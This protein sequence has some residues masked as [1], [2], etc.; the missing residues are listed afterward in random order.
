[1]AKVKLLTLAD[2]FLAMVPKLTF[3]TTT[4][5]AGSSVTIGTVTSGTDYEVTLGLPSGPRGL[6]GLTPNFTIG[7]V[8]ASSSGG[9][10]SAALRGT[11]DNPIL[12][13]TI[14]RGLTGATPNI[15]IGSTLTSAAGGSATVSVGGTAESPV[16]TFTI[17]RG[18]TGL[19]PNLTIGT[20]STGAPG[21]SVIASFRGT[22]DNP[23]LDL[24]VPRGTTGL[25]PNLTIGNVTSSAAGTSATVSLRGTT[26]NPILDVNIPRGA[27][28][29]T[30]SITAGTITTGAPGSSVIASFRGTTDNP[31]LDLTIPRGTVGVTPAFTIGNVTTGASGTAAAAGLRGTAESPIL[32]LTIPRGLTGLTPNL[33]I[34]NVTTLTPGSNATASFRGTVDN[35][36]LDLAIPRGTA[37][38]G[39][40]DVVAANNGSEYATNKD[41]FHANLGAG[42]GVGGGRSVY[43]AT[44]AAAVRTAIGAV[45]ASAIG[46]AAM[47]NVG[48]TSGTVAVLESNG[49]FN[50]ARIPVIM[51]HALDVL[52]PDGSTTAPGLRV[53]AASSSSSVNANTAVLQLTAND[54][55]VYGSLTSPGAQQ[56]NWDG[57][58][59]LPAATN[60]LGSFFRAGTSTAVMSIAGYWNALNTVAL[61]DNASIT[62]DFSTGINFTLTMTTGVGVSRSF[63]APTNLKPGQRGFFR[64]VQPAV[65]DADYRVNW[66][67]STWKWL[68]SNTIEPRF[69]VGNSAVTTL[70]YLVTQAGEVQLFPGKLFATVSDIRVGTHNGAALTPGRWYDA[71]QP[72]GLTDAS[73]IN[74]DLS[75][76]INFTLTMT[77]GIGATRALT[78]S[79]SKVGQRGFIRFVS[80]AGIAAGTTY[81]S[82]F[83]SGFRFDG[84]T[85]PLFN[86]GPNAVTVLDYEVTAFGELTITGGKTSTLAAGSAS[87]FT[88]GTATTAVSPASYW[89]AQVPVA[90]T[91]AA[92]VAIDP[93]TG[94]NF[95]LT[96]TTAIGTSRILAASNTASKIGQRGFIRIVHPGSATPH[97]IS[98][99]SA[100]RF[101]DGV[102]IAPT[103]NQTAFGVTVIDYEITA[104]GEISLGQGRMIATS[105]DILAGTSNTFLTPATY[106][107][108]Q[109][110]TTLTDSALVVFDFATAINFNLV[111]TTAVGT[112]R[113]FTVNNPNLV[114]VGQRGFIRVVQPAGIPV[115]TVYSAAFGSN[116]RY[117]DNSTSP[118]FN[119]NANA[120]TVFDYEITASQEISITGGRTFATT[121]EFL[122]GTST[123]ALNIATFWAGQ[124]P[125]VLTDASTV[126][127][128]LSKGINFALDM[129]TATGATRTVN[130][131]NLRVGQRGFIRVTQPTDFGLNNF[132]VNW[133]SNYY[134]N[135]GADPVLNTGYTAVT[136][137]HYDV[138]SATRILLSA[139][140]PAVV[141]SEATAAEYRSATPARVLAPD[142]VWA[143]NAPVTLSE[144]D[145]QNGVN[146]NNF[147]N[148]TV[149]ISTYSY[150]YFNN[151]ANPVAAGMK[152]GQSGCITFVVP[153]AGSGGLN[154][155]IPFFS[156]NDQWF[157]SNGTVPT[158]PINNPGYTF[159]M[160]YTITSTNT[161]DVFFAMNMGRSYDAQAKAY[162]DAMT[163]QPETSRKVLINN[164]IVGLKND[165]VW[166]LLDN[167]WLLASHDNQSSRVNAVRPS[168]VLTLYGSP[169]FVT[170]LGWQATSTSGQV[171]NV[172]LQTPDA[173]NGGVNR[174][175]SA[176]DGSFGFWQ[177]TTNSETGN[178][179]LIGEATNNFY[180][181]LGH[182]S[183]N[184]LTA[185]IAGS[186]SGL[187]TG[188]QAKGLR[189]VSH[190]TGDANQTIFYN[191]TGYTSAYG[192]QN[193]M[194]G[195]AK[196][197]LLNAGNPGSYTGTTNRQAAAFTGQGMTSTQLVAMNNR[198]NTYL[199]AIGAN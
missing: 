26:D 128:D 188:G 144:A 104:S 158:F 37:G 175:Q 88:T 39:T 95:T 129:T 143:A 47:Y 19:T 20:V 141:N 180:D 90:L 167:L 171:A 108:S 121:S 38:A 186:N 157:F 57:L 80:P 81:V 11:V 100:Y 198:L 173:Y 166:S 107:A 16:L 21:T 199:T 84:G 62:P 111:L 30:P 194:T 23:I 126:S 48:T 60:A 24:T 73:S 123:A 160:Y 146:F 55:T 122:T 1:V 113:T 56:L 138:T 119:P 12:D 156:F 14:P 33:T 75:T 42:T 170:N 155:I 69:N 191:S 135:S 28:G 178:G 130:F 27:T 120:I 169:Y 115:G 114:R 83:S 110:T 52:T 76:A 176:S 89:G 18:N 154:N 161:V 137:I 103:L 187:A 65:T 183:A 153:T 32:D 97:G 34:G 96:M 193:N 109:T 105:S 189:A 74:L 152:P 181:Y 190:V 71:L 145:F 40:G 49:V 31:I 164:L 6:T 78:L 50:A 41:S 64:I 116:F 172:G 15:S 29:L 43:Y 7:N 196:F 79:N 92:T 10:A 4:L 45:A 174:R 3:K 151:V 195:S 127:L 192:N 101:M 136:I 67:S 91:D 22:T 150:G 70:E 94:I 85:A 133:G 99:S 46:T 63:N 58:F 9:A 59:Y 163:L 51:G 17:P 5:A 140:K 61:T 139:G 168:N 77:T 185:R 2:A 118:L 53:R 25:T 184:T 86:A 124:T 87:D 142:K 66:N 82:T 134:T 8:V 132:T 54:G 36:I 165:G 44:D 179:Y 125:V 112:S 148:A 13:L 162:F 147:I 68:D 149:T 182:S 102:T 72:V 117:G 177:N 98:W 93:T 197:Y 35:P 131:S 106:W 159:R